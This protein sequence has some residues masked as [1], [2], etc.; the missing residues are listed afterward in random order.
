MTKP[1]P[2]H[3]ADMTQAKWD[4]LTRQ[5]RDAM[6]DTSELHPKLL[7]YVGKR[8]R[9][10]PKR[11]YGLTSFIVGTSTGW[12]PCMLAMRNDPR[13]HGSSDVIRPNEQIDTVTVL[14]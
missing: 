4:A 8:V 6:R 7:A 9:V 13:S 5:E 2:A 14:K 11:E 1:L 10:T 3:L 12:R